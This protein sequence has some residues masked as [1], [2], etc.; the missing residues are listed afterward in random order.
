M[1]NSI[2]S[3][4]MWMF[5]SGIGVGLLLGATVV[6]GVLLERGQSEQNELQFPTQ[7]LHATATHGSDTFA[8]ATGQIANGVEGLFTLDFLTG[9][10]RCAVI[11]SRTGEMGGMFLQNIVQHLQVQQGKKPNYLLVT[12]A[13]SIR[14]GAGNV[15]P[16]DSI[17]YVMDANTG[18]FAAYTLP[19]NNNAVNF[20]AAQAGPMKL[21][22]TGTARN[23]NL[24]E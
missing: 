4:P 16:A 2:R 6:V 3:K 18:K 9:D 12:G 1:N 15:R 23:V 22:G 17:A 21:I 5:A 7:A 11:N 13:I 24:Q 14:G 20:N 10:L 8:I 19:W